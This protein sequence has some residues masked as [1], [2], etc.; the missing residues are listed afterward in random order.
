MEA[1][2]R[3]RAR[4]GAA[5][6]V[7][8]ASAQVVFGVD[9]SNC[10]GDDPAGAADAGDVWSVEAVLSP[11]GPGEVGPTGPSVRAVVE[12]VDGETGVVLQ[13]E[14]CYVAPRRRH[15]AAGRRPPPNGARPTVAGVNRRARRAAR[16]A[17][18]AVRLER[19]AV[20][21]KS[22][23]DCRLSHY[24]QAPAFYAS[25]RRRGQRRDPR[26]GAVPGRARGLATWRDAQFG[27]SSAWS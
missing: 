17:R 11:G 6:S 26:L 8:D 16:A 10:Y 15:L 19:D 25:R 21:L 12:V 23:D 18:L 7:A 27:A 20:L 2:G 4:A 13:A 14:A 22:G 1:H 5:E 24:P 9:A 3:A